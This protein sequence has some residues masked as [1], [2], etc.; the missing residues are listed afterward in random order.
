MDKE[1]IFELQKIDS[2]CNDCKFM[3]RDIDKRKSFDH[4]HENQINASH[5]LNYG[6][7][8]KLNINVSFIANLCQPQT[9]NC[10]EHRKS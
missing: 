7:C 8:S 9:V 2:N 1:S 10:F 3:T 6:K 5:R 4:L